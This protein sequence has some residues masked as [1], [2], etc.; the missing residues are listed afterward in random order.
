VASDD[1]CAV[2][3][4]G[5]G[6][7]IELREAPRLKRSAALRFGPR[8]GAGPGLVRS[9][10][11]ECGVSDHRRVALLNLEH[12]RPVAAVTCVIERQRELVVV[13]PA[14][15]D[16]PIAAVNPGGRDHRRVFRVPGIAYVKV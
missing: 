1:A 10:D 16:H 14:A 6:G 15:C 4:H 11:G 8:P 12:R 2:R 5:D 13:A 7:V 3:K 9:A